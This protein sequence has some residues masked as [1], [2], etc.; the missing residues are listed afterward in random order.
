MTDR[1]LTAQERIEAR[2]LLQEL[3]ETAKTVRN[4]MDPQHGMLAIH[5]SQWETQYHSLI[6]ELEFFTRKMVDRDGR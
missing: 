5:V 2:H 4:A 1:L 3:S 6:G